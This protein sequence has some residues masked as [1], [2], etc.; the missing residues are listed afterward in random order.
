KTRRFETGF[1][2]KPCA[3]LCKEF[4]GASA[5]G[6]KLSLGQSTVQ[7]TAPAESSITCTKP[8]R[9]GVLA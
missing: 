1:S 5:M 7:E 9:L 2:R 3:R 6:P 8:L 4:L